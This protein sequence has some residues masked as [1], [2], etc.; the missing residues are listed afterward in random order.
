MLRKVGQSPRA[1]MELLRQTLRPIM[2]RNSKA[3]VKDELGVPP[4]QDKLV[5]LWMAQ[6]SG[7]PQL[8][9]KRNMQ[10]GSVFDVQFCKDSPALLAVGGSKGKLGIWNTLELEQVQ[11]GQGLAL[12]FGDA[13]LTFITRSSHAHYM[14]RT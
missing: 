6:P 12:A 1:G 8:V 2:W 9:A 7:P 3:H 14:L 11:A 4:M 10:L 5:K 13:H